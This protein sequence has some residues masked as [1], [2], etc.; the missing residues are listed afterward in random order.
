LRRFKIISP[1]HFRA[2]KQS[3]LWRYRRVTFPSSRDR[4]LSDE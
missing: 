1:C 3:A 4:P 2:G